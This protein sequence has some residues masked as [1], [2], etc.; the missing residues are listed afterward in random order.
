M[1][2]ANEVQLTG[3]LVPVAVVTKETELAEIYERFKAPVVF[4]GSYAYVPVPECVDPHLYGGYTEERA[5]G[6]NIEVRSLGG[7]AEGRVI[8]GDTQQRNVDGDIE[9]RGLGGDTENRGVGGDMTGRNL[10]GDSEGRGID[11]NMEARNLAGEIEMRSIDGNISGRG[12]GGDTE[13]RSLD[14][15]TQNL[16]CV[17]LSDATGFTI[18]GLKTAGPVRVF[19]RRGL[20]VLNGLVVQE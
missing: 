11:G 4:V 12:L 2:P 13:N 19:T 9:R 6:G 1:I 15:A 7:G 18:G 17:R 5:L 20:S 16:V 10:G 14:G 8:G 3:R